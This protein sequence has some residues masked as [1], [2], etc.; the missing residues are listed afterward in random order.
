VVVSEASGAV[1]LLAAEGLVRRYGGRAV[2]DVQRLEIGR[3]EVVA[4]LGPNGAGKSTLFR[5]LLGIEAPDAG[6]L[7]LD[8]RRLKPG[9]EEL[10]RRVVGVFQRPH[11]FSGT[12]RDNLRFGLRANEVPRSEW[13][14]RIDRVTA[15]L[16][17]R[18]LQEARVGSLSGGEA[19]RVALARGLVLDPD[20]LMLDEPTASLDVTVRRRFR[21]ELGLVMRERASSVLLITHD[22]SDAFDL[23]D[24]VAVM[25]RGRIVQ[26]GTPEDLTTEPAT[27][28][29]ATF[30][31][32]ELLL[33]GVVDRV[34]EGTMDVLAGGARLVARCAEGRLEAG[35][36]VH[37]RY[38]P[39]DVVLTR[40]VS[41]DT[42]ARNRLRMTVRSVTPVG[43]LVRVRLDGPVTL[44]ALVTRDSAERME[45]R[46]GTEITALLKTTALNVYLPESPRPRD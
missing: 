14:D 39:E 9:S 11:L 19:Q 7:R 30:T 17:I 24:R 13:S 15:E 4:V 2:V 3:R 36:R 20:L 12:V 28:F 1:P 5:L 22:P 27:A 8:G 45:I 10:R 23:A 42:S 34:G 35:D 43:G 6:E 37:V 46:V 29:V 40:A 41:P 26:V 31:G 21:E 38:R 33:D 18:G 16:G 25:E 44:A 32:A